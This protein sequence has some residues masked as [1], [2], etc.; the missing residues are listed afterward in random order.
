[1]SLISTTQDDVVQVQVT[2]T[3]GVAAAWGIHHY[4]KYSCN[5]HV[6]WDVSQLG[7]ERFWNHNAVKKDSSIIK[8]FFNILWKTDDIFWDKFRESF[9]FFY[10]S[11]DNFLGPLA[12][13]VLLD[14]YP[15]P[16]P[17]D[18]W[19][20]L[21]STRHLRYCIWTENAISR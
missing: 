6:S 9:W 14:Q 21:F 7:E 12:S 17:I 2:A 18:D 10:K 13:S 1:V 11:G 4:L 3:T 16:L 8:S 15:I 19:L 5:V 20:Y